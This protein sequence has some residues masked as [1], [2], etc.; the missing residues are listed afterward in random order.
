MG[1]QQVGG[2]LSL[3][4]ACFGLAGLAVTLLGQ[5]WSSLGV[6]APS[7]IAEGCPRRWRGSPSRGLDISCTF[8]YGRQLSE[9]FCSQTLT[10]LVTSDEPGLKEGH[11]PAAECIYA[12]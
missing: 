3:Q 12:Y 10:S 2:L 6:W 8:G 5:G 4:R 9:E 1:F 7:S 11:L